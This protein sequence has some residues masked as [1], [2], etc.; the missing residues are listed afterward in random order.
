MLLQAPN[1]DGG[2]RGRDLAAAWIR[3]MRQGDFEAAWAIS[4]RVL[5]SSVG[6]DS[7]L[8]QH[9]QSIWNGSS[10]DGQRV[11]VRCYQGLG[12]AIQYS[13]FLP[14]LAQVAREVTV[15]AQAMLVPLLACMPDWRGR[16][17]PLHD[18][19]PEVEYDVDI[20]IMELPHALRTSL[21]TLPAQ[22]PYFD[23]VPALPLSPDKLQVGVM[24]SAGTWDPRRCIPSA[25]LAPLGNL[26]GVALYNLRPGARV[27]GALDAST[28]DVLQTA[29]RV[30]SLDLVI[31]VDTM[32]AHLAGAL[33]VP[34]W[35]LLHAECDWRWMEGR[36]DSPWYPSMRLFRQP[37]PGNWSA[38]VDELTERLAFHEPTRGDGLPPSRP[39]RL[40]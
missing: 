33:N 30:A 28:A 15:W 18:G 12:D 3:A 31:S 11:L 19:V 29:A 5:A 7:T 10:L 22:T 6:R 38:V 24:A 35:T 37:E 23:V 14:Q 4:D 32:M 26:P 2:V 21:A 20:E 1:D 9:Q 27:P 13:R 25:L 8:P 36:D 40:R 34:T 17:L 16:L 39:D